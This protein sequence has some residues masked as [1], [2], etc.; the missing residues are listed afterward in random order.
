MDDLVKLAFLQLSHTETQ[1]IVKVAGILAR[2]KNWLKGKFSPEFA[3]S[4]QILKEK[5]SQT[6]ELIDQLEVNI[7]KLQSAIKDGELSVYEAQLNIVKQLS[8]QLIAQ[9]KD[10]NDTI[11]KTKKN[12]NY[13]DE[14]DLKSPE[15]LE[16]FRQSLPENFN[17]E[18]GKMIDKPIKSIEYYANLT[19]EQIRLSPATLTNIL[20]KIALKLKYDGFPFSPEN[21][22]IEELKNKVRQSIVDGT[23]TEANIKPPSKDVKHQQLG[24][25]ELTVSSAP[26]VLPNNNIILQAEFSILDLSTRKSRTKTLSLRGTRHMTVLGS[27]AAS[28]SLSFLR[29]LAESI[30]KKDT[31]LNNVE[32]AEVMRQGY[33]QVFGQEPSAEVLG[34]GWAQIATEEGG[35]KF[36][37]PCNNVGNIRAGK[38]WIESGKPYYTI[39]TK[40]LSPEGHEIDDPHATFRAFAT[41]QEGAASY[42]SL[43]KSSYPISLQWMQSGDAEASG[44]TLGLKGYYTASIKKYSS[45]V[46]RYY[47][48][49]QRDVLPKLSGIKSDVKPPPGEK[50]LIKDYVGQYSKEEKENILHPANPIS[51]KS[52]PAND[53]DEVNSLFHQLVA[54]DSVLSIIKQSSSN[55]RSTCLIRFTNDNQI[56]NCVFADKLSFIVQKYLRAQTQIHQKDKHIDLQISNTGDSLANYHVIQKIAEI[57][58][59]QLENTTFKK[60]N[61]IIAPNV[62]SNFSPIN[63]KQ[64][65]H[66]LAKFAEIVNHA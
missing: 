13:Y 15:F 28:S 52:T 43:I 26:F 51:P 61:F 33:K 59:N 36:I 20:E 5:S 25:I 39:G 66:N 2:I 11:Q 41:P 30:P 9:I 19:P 24:S 62:V 16:K 46:Q 1:E 40:E 7:D 44:A 56:L 6:K 45:T 22:N 47:D 49:F 18:I 14:E 63:P 55:Q 32:F 21:I 37:L 48:M 8:I 53:N 4:L 42:W 3:Q 65:S 60:S 38:Q 29:K 57:L 12:I 10:T 17:L 35:S 27:K 23:L 58:S 34:I 54:R 50:P 31:V 64:L